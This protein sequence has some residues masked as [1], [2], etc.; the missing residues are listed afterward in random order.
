MTAQAIYD[1]HQS[2]SLPLQQEALE[3]LWVC[4]PDIAE[5]LELPELDSLPMTYAQD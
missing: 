2:E 4:C 1:A 5:D 3:W